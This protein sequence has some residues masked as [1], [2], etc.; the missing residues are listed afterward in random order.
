MGIF[1][2]LILILT[3]FLIWLL[4]EYSTRLFLK[5]P[6][7]YYPKWLRYLWNIL[8]LLM[9]WGL[10]NYLGWWTV[11]ITAVVLSFLLDKIFPIKKG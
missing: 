2:F 7:K 1:E 10:V 11:G 5:P 8:I 9:I 6:K 4:L 3:M